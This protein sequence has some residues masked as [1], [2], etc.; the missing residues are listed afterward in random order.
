MFKKLKEFWDDYWLYLSVVLIVLTV[1]FLAQ[2]DEQKIISFCEQ[3][4]ELDRVT[5]NEDDC[6]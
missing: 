1:P 3:K 2:Q 5:Y 6:K 4:C